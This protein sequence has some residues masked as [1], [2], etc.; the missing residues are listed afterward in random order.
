MELFAF[1]VRGWSRRLAGRPFRERILLL[2]IGAAVALTLLLLLSVGLGV[3]GSHRLA[4]IEQEY[5][6]SLREGREL[7]ETMNA[8][9]VALES[10]VATRDS[11]RFTVTDSLR[12]AFRQ[13]ARSTSGQDG[14]ALMMA[15]ANDFEVYYVL[16]RRVSGQMMAGVGGDALSASVT[17]MVTSYNTLRKS[18]TGNISADERKIEAAFRSARKL[19]VAASAA[20]ALIALAAVIAL[21]T[22]AVAT[23]RSVTEPLDEVIAVAKRIAEGDMSVTIPAGGPDEVGRLLNAMTGMVAY[24]DE[25]SAVAQAISSGDLSSAVTPRSE[26]DRFGTALSAMVRYLSDMSSLADRLA[27]GDLT[28]QVAARSSE[29]A[30]GH[31]FAAMIERLHTLVSE[32]RG[33]A[34]SIAAAASQMR[35]SSHE[36]ATSSSEEADEIRHTSQ[37]LSELSISVRHNADR[38]RQMERQALEAA[39]STQ[40]GASIVQESIDSAR[41]IFSRTS[42]IENIARQT[43]LLSLN[44]AIE[45]ARA[46]EHGRGFNVVADEI[47]K[48]A[49]ESAKTASEISRL[50]TDSQEK[51][52]RSHQILGALGPSIAGT[53]RLVQELAA[54][55]SE[56]AAG[57]TEVEQAM[58]RV[59]DTT[60]RNAATAEEFAATAQE[61]STQAERLEELIG[62]FHT[63]DGV[64]RARARRG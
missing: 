46:G 28:V 33:T 45:A 20:V 13:H 25:M 18:I 55:S 63:S 24:L 19:Q 21:G 52:E 16:A 22:L 54:A 1:A 6:P 50:T 62:H 38:S 36:L 61:M 5:Y 14:A 17:Q 49:Q 51:G 12:D 39:S 29:D 57:L 53:A 4:K 26:R 48:L 40:E 44:A 59:D 23:T 56:Q 64:G 8:L 3:L 11:E 37:R 41:E 32:L 15:I 2:P 31:A 27:R 30:F 7:R 9:Q 60:R 43:N 42:V 47:R 58:V 34:E 35:S 10:A